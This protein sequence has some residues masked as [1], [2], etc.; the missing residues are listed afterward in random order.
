[1]ELFQYPTNNPLS[2]N[3]R[4][5]RKSSGAIGDQFIKRFTGAEE[6]MLRYKSMM[7]RIT[8]PPST[9][10]SAHRKQLSNTS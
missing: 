3:I 10:L 5:K 4:V 1:M 6:N 7:A 8:L 2:R 9:D